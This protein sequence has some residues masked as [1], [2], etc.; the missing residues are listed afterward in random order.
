MSAEPPSAPGEPSSARPAPE[1][2][3]FDPN[4]YP[5]PGYP[6][7]GG[8]PGQPGGY[9]G[10]PGG[11]PP[12]VPPTGGRYPGYPPQGYPPNGYPPPGY[13]PAGQ[14][15]NGATRQH[16][17]RTPY[18]Q[19]PRQPP[20]GGG[21]PRGTGRPGSQR[22]AVWLIVII[23]VVVILLRSHRISSTEV[24]VFCVL[25]P[26]VMLHEISHGVVALFFGDDTAKRAGRITLNPLRHVTL[27]GTIIV[28]IITVIAG[29]GWFGWAKP[30]PVDVR[31]LRHPRNE[32]V[33]V[34][35]AGPLTNVLLAAIFGV[36]FYVVYAAGHQGSPTMLTPVGARIL[37]YG[38]FIN[39]WV[40][41]F[42][43]IPIPPLDGSALVERL[44]PRSWWPGYLRFRMYGMFIILGALVLMSLSGTSPLQWV[45][46]HLVTW[47]AHVVH[48]V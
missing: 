21:G 4:A 29:L 48:A 30:V 41:C 31:K 28:P 37:F 12:P 18:L 9:P 24:I 2:R 40:A 34:S 13:P 22:S 38:G 16:A 1:D 11:Y 3:P 35:L 25:I 17:W 36:L 46:I 10:Q 20:P 8:Y 47:W 44:L 23:A 33:L 32:T 19:R 26:S 42:N 43:M 5:P 27:L 6:P 7:G 14:P 39:L 45:V 15:P